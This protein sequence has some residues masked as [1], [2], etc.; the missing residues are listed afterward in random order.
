MV[1]DFCRDGFSAR[2]LPRRLKNSVEIKRGRKLNEVLV[3]RFRT[4]V[5]V[6]HQ[7]E[8][9][10]SVKDHPGHSSFEFWYNP[11]PYRPE[12]RFD[13]DST[14]TF[15]LV[16]PRLLSSVNLRRL[17]DEEHLALR[18]LVANP[19]V[20]TSPL[21]WVHL[22]F[23]RATEG[24]SILAGL[25]R[26]PVILAHGLT[27]HILELSGLIRDPSRRYLEAAEE[28]RKALH[29]ISA[30]NED[31][32]HTVI[33]GYPFILKPEYD[34]QQFFSKPRFV[35]TEALEDGK[36]VSKTLSRGGPRP[37]E[38]DGLQSNLGGVRRE[39]PNRPDGSVR[40]RPEVVQAIGS[41]ATIRVRSSLRS[42]V[43]PAIG[44]R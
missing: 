20:E 40:G 5:P 14:K 43:D 36:R 21:P 32:I 42:E 8:L 11:K 9:F 18:S 7:A 22:I 31:A 3:T 41:P 34:Y 16:A 38:P 2:L 30:E 26:D 35:V 13:T 28:L 17:I 4:R 12:I 37:G 25:T 15:H 23:T 10:F 39:P 33:E 6:G 19:Q 27:D 29:A 24:S 44:F 1:L